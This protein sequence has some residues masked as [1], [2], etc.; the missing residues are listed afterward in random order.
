VTTTA[1]TISAAPP[2]VAGPGRTSSSN[3]PSATATSG[4]TYWC[5]TTCEIGALPSSQ[6]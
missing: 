6:A 3:A 2:S 1:P 5:V 4:F